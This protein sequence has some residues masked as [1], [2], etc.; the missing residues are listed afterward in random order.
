MPLLL[1][2][3]VPVLS[4]NRMLFKFALPSVSINPV[5]VKEVPTFNLIVSLFEVI[6]DASIVPLLLIV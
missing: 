5:L 3:L 1:I 6:F 4:I 2:E